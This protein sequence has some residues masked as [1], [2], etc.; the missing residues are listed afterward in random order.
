MEK[1]SIDKKALFA[2]ASETRIEILR[3]LDEKRMTLTEM[4]EELGISKP[5][6]K[7][8]ITKL[9]EVGLIRKR[10]EGRKWIYYELTPK[11][12]QILHP[13]SRT[14]IILMLFSAIVALIGGLFEILRFVSKPVKPLPK[15]T[16]IPA[17]TRPPTQTPT[18][19]PT[20]TP[21][22]TPVPTVGISPE[23]HLFV[24]I[25]LV[26]IGIVLLLLY[27]LRSRK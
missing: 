27:K 24:G 13:E 2:L 4:A 11:G 19:T 23:L 26:L 20:P 12:R 22:P 17:P 3:K 14:K 6:V 8:H 18:P 9:E 15:P 1:I 16:P 7:K 21:I 10:D 5:A 25:I